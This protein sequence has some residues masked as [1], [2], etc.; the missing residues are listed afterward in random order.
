M[1]PDPKGVVERVLKASSTKDEV[2]DED[3]AKVKEVE[4]LFRIVVVDWLE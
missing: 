3:V 1:A 4:A 2:A